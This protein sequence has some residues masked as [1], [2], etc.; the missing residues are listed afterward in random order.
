MVDFGRRAG[1]YAIYRAGFPDEL[2]SRLRA[3]GLGLGGQRALD[4]GTGTG[5][6]ARGLAR[7]GCTVYGLDPSV[8]LLRQ[9]RRLDDEAGLPASYLAGRAE[10]VGLAGRRF[11][12]VTAGQ[13]WHWFAGDRA[14]S[15]VRRL[16]VPGGALAVCHLDYL[17][18]PGNVC[19]AT[20]ELILERNPAWAM[21][22]GTGIHPAWTLDVAG[23]G[24]V[25]LETFSFEVAIPY[26]HE[27][28]R[29]RMRTCNGVNALT[30]VE[31]ED[32]DQAL[33]RLLARDFPGDPLV[34]PHR[35]WALVAWKP[36]QTC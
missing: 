18:L 14:A 32:F 2:F 9:A 7:A 27:A 17:P 4:L 1:D 22:G 36:G 21:T 10:E 23:A 30:E 13:C 33:G 6:L 19:Q 35:V 3:M 8:P 25:G 31:L 11:D 26:T 12:V 5:N 20:E 24:L 29:G 15:E 28:W 34:V 16:L